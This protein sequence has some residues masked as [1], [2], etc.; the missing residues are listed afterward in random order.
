[1]KTVKLN[2]KQIKAINAPEDNVL[3]I[4]P[5]GSGKTTTLVE[6]IKKYK[7]DNPSANVVAITFTRKSAEDLR[8]KL[9]GYGGITASTIHSWAY[10]ELDKLAE[11]L[12]KE[13]PNYGFKIKLLQEDKIKEILLDIA[14][15]K[16]YFYI[17]VD[18]LYSYIMGNYNMD[19][20]DSLKTVFQNILHEYILYKRRYGLYDFTD[21]PLYLLDKLNDYNKD[22]EHIDGLFVDEFQDVDDI[23][24]EVFERVKAEKKFYIGDPQQSIYIFRGA[25]AEVMKKLRN[26]KLYNLD[27]NYRS[28]QEIVDFASTYQEIA[29]SDPMLF[30]AQLESYTSSILCKNGKGGNVFVLNRAGSAYQVNEYMKL[31]GK[32]IVE[33]FLDKEPMILCRKNKEV[34]EIQKLGYSKVQTIHQAKGLEYPAVIVTDFEINGTEDINVAYVAMTRAETD[35]LAA[36]YPAFIKILEE[37]KKEAPLR[38]FNNLF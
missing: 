29:Q 22:I 25:S 12:Q 18:I 4:A 35:L 17:K 8:K 14:K 2:E 33:K 34:R 21:L 36:N 28:N 31:K 5:A 11:Q 37:L 13:D 24:L 1:M 10:Q 32:E 15:Q 3:I 26:F 38:K 20:S 19:I 27:V 16:R 23:Q 9:S 30:S 6:S 7:D